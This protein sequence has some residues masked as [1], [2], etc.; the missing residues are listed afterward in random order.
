MPLSTSSMSIVDIVSLEDLLGLDEAED[1]HI[2]CCVERERFVCG[3]EFHPEL[4]A[5]AD[6][7]DVHDECCPTCIHIA[8]AAMCPRPPK[9]PSHCHCPFDE[10]RLCPTRRRTRKT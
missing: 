9:T 1:G 7:V 8:E 6:L 3:A 2:V 4:V 10:N 5:D